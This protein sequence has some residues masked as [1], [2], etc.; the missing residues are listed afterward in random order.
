MLHSIG[1]ITAFYFLLLVFEGIITSGHICFS[2]GLKQME[3]IGFG[4][5]V[6]LEINSPHTF[7]PSFFSKTSCFPWVFDGFLKRSIFGKNGEASPSIVSSCIL[8]RFR[9][10]RRSAPF[11]APPSARSSSAERPKCF[12]RGRRRAG[13]IHWCESS[14][15]CKNMANLI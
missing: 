11:E 7:Q 8:N 15:R 10:F 13:V 6:V 5:S 3:I 4:S 14:H 9:Q 2:R 1:L 12:S